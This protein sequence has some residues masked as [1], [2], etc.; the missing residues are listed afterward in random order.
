[1]QVPGTGRS[2]SSNP[3]FTAIFWNH[4][5]RAVT[6]NREHIDGYQILYQELIQRMDETLSG[7]S[8]YLQLDLKGITPEEGDLKDRLPD[9][10]KIIHKDISEIPLREI[11]N[12]WKVELNQ[13]D[14][15]F[16]EQKCKKHL[17]NFEFEL[18]A[19]R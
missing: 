16:I 10:H 2:M 18:S 1:T 14:I 9:G 6:K 12:K 19:G 15:V 17:I 7:L 4:Y 11:I 8:G 3:V 13:V 5:V